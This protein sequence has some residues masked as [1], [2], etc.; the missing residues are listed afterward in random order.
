MLQYQHEE[1]IKIAHDNKLLVA[2]WNTHSASDNIEAINKN[3]DF[4]QTDKVKNL[5]K[6]L[7]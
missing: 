7:K 2:I 3:P 5:I 1:Q 6:L 4:T